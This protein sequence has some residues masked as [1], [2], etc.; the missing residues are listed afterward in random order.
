MRLVVDGND[1]TGKSTT[2]ALL[3]KLGYRVMDRGLPTDLTD[4]PGSVQLNLFEFYLILDVPVEVSRARLAKAGRNLDEKYHT[5]KDLTHYR[6]RFK[7]VAKIL[8]DQAVLVDA[9]GTPEE[10]VSAILL[11]LSERSLSRTV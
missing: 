5:V 8:G 10:V 6:E 7:A 2:A 11:I 3:R 9:S 4:H 1:G